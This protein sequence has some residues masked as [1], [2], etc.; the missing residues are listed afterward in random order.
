MGSTRLRLAASVIVVLVTA[1]ACSSAETTGARGLSETATATAT[2]ETTAATTTETAAST[3]LLAEAPV[4]ALPVEPSCVP[5]QGAQCDGADLTGAKLAGLDLTG[6]SLKG[7]NLTDAILVHANLSGADLS[8][9][10]LTG[11]DFTR[12]NLSNASLRGSRWNGTNLT[13]AVTTL[14][15][16]DTTVTG[17]RKCKTTMAQGVIDSR[18]CPC[19]NA[20]GAT[21]GF[22]PPLATMG[23]GAIPYFPRGFEAAAGQ[24]VSI[25]QNQAV[26]ALMG[27]TWGGNGR[28][29]FALPRVTGPWAGVRTGNDGAGSCLQW[30]VATRGFYPSDPAHTVYPGEVYLS[31]AVNGPQRNSMLEAGAAIDPTISALLGPGFTA[32]A[33]PAG[34][35]QPAEPPYLAELRL[36]SKSQP[37][38][39]GFVPADGSTIAGAGSDGLKQLLGDRLPRVVAPDGYQWAVSTQGIY[40]T[41]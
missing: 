17:A 33:I 9:A 4:S 7:A 37:L 1:T 36:F 28:T 31:A 27:N 39:A 25:N 10:T 8:G 2:A 30:S 11:A 34:W 6:I 5:F 13:E 41:N 20:G 32:Y 12:A 29:T 16:F 3:E 26:F 18:D 35:P 15:P 24:L 19:T 21:S 40:P 22:E 38:P 23:L 14:D